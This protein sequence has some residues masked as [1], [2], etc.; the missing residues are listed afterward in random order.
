MEFTYYNMYRSLLLAYVIYHIFIYKMSNIYTSLVGIIIL[1]Y[2]T[3]A[4]EGVYVFL[5]FDTVT[6]LLR[7]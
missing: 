3:K 1:S 6:F 5:M 7:L 4:Q 2:N